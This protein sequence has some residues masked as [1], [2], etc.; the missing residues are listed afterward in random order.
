[1]IS[2]AVQKNRGFTLVEALAVVT[3]MG[4][5]LP[6][7]MY[8]VSMVTEAAGLV[9][10]RAAAVEIASN[11]MTETLVENTWQNG[12]SNGQITAD[13]GQFNWN[14]HVED[15]IE[16]NLHQITVQ[17]TWASRGKERSVALSTIVYDG[18]APTQ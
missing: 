17:V 13:A 6:V 2:L 16:S 12:D 3:M 18:E 8:G 11:Q 7:V 1:M 9:K 5:V 14:S 15:W 10:Q 4:I